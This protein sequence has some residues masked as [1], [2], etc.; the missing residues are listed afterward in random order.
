LLTSDGRC[1]RLS[2][3]QFSIRRFF[4]RRN[5]DTLFSIIMSTLF[6]G[7]ARGARPLRFGAHSRRVKPAHRRRD[8]R[9]GWGGK[10]HPSRPIP[11]TREPRFQVVEISGRGSSPFK[12]GELRLR[13]G[14]EWLYAWSQPA[15]ID[16][17]GGGQRS[18]V[19][20]ADA[21]FSLY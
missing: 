6:C 17:R 12:P 2:S 1:N 10:S 19:S 4:Q 20:A 14:A 9:S 16:S 13:P 8:G 7:E 3:S 18:L 5:I 21:G 15:G 11:L